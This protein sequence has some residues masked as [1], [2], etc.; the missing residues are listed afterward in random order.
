MASNILSIGKSALN[1]AQI[2][3]STTGHNIANAS[4]PGYSRQVVVQAAAQAQNFGYGFIGQGAEVTGVSRV[5][6]EILARQMISLQ[7]T[8]AA[9]TTYGNQLNAIDNMLSDETAGLN[10]AM[11]DFFAGVQAL[12]SKPND[13]PTR[14]TMLSNA[15]SLVNRFNSMDSRLNEIEQGVNNQLVSSVSLVNS[16]AKQIAS[17]N[18]IIEQSIST[19][20]NVPNDLMDQRD[21]LIS[22]LSKQIKTTVVPQNQGTYNVFVGNGLPLVVGEDTYNLVTTTSPTNP[23]R[24]EV[25]YQSASKVTVLGASSLS[26]GAI[27]GLVQFRSESLDQVQ[28]QIGQIA[29]ALAGS[30][31]AQHAQGL[32]RNGQPGGPLFNIPAPVATSSSLNTGNGELSAQIVDPSLVTSSNYR[33]QYDGTNYKV[34]RLSDQSAQTYASLPQTI[35]GLTI[36]QASGTI[37]AGDDF[38]IQP[39]ANAAATLSLAIKDVNKLAVGSPVL[40]SSLGV[41]NTGSGAISAVKVDSTYASSPL[42]TALNFTYN[43][44]LPSTLTLAP[45]TLPVTV[46]YGGVSTTYP[47]GAPITYTSGATVSVSGTSFALSGTP[48]NGDQFTIAPGTSTG[49]GDN[50]NGLLLADLQTIG[51]VA[52][53]GSTSKNTYTTAFSQMVSSVGNKSRELK[54]TGEAEVKALGQAT[55]AMQSESGVNLDE[56]ATNLIRYQ[57]AYQAAGK[58]MQIA[59]ELFDVLLQLG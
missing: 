6:N 21:Q 33:V 38:L 25:G 30:F 10:P 55:A 3:L 17:L 47:A 32:D 35:D 51:N 41:G 4:T 48:A 39:T 52:M 15:Q 23:S 28:N 50:R 22:E 37:N 19:T 9:Y 7:S 29:V 18:D 12:A 20:G 31:N 14:Q 43:S 58:M 16:Y 36:S 24:I 54:V 2:G 56:E 46:T 11:N 13:I 34:T 1:A 57:Q 45:S 5:Y 49:A 40:S 26:G 44:G 27:G 42:S 59:S 53:L 8:G